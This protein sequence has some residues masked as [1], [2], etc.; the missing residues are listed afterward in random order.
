ML[1]GVRERGGGGGGGGVYDEGEGGGVAW[2]GAAGVE[3]NEGKEGKM[4]MSEF[5]EF[6]SH[7]RISL[8]RAISLSPSIHSSFLRQLPPSSLFPLPLSLS[9]PLPRSADTRRGCL[10]LT[11]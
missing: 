3:Q 9:I 6:L 1:A 11:N 7:F 2:C 8:S 4:W 10:T 5:L